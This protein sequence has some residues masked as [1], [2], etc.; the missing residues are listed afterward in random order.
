MKR[1][2]GVVLAGLLTV[3]SVAF[4]AGY[5]ETSAA[6]K[7]AKTDEVV[8]LERATALIGA[9]VYGNDREDIGEIEDL[10]LAPN[11]NEISYAVVSFGGFMDIGDKLFAVPWKALTYSGVDDTFT[12]PVEKA[13]LENAPGFE[14]DNWPNTGDVMWMREIDTYYKVPR[15][16][17]AYSA[18]EDYER[19]QTARLTERATDVD[20]KVDVNL[21]VKEGTVEGEMTEVQEERHK[22]AL[23]MRRVSNLLGINIENPAGDDIAELDDALVD[24][25][26]GNVPYAL[27]S[28]GGFWEIAESL[29]AVPFPAIQRIADEER[30]LMTATREQLEASKIDED[31]LAYLERE[32]FGRDVYARFEIQPFW[33][34]TERSMVAQQE[35]ET[36]PMQR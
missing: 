9:N 31:N 17:K 7:A 34:D 19:Q 6:E 3:T 32:D 20:V 24:I 14:K 8:A 23:D 10:V 16:D 35:P 25:D 18:L 2:V 26:S 1:A 15:D 5:G 27:V 13:V 28:F 4:A 22:M 11:A 36:S 21:D 30:L 33:A 29:A 12:L